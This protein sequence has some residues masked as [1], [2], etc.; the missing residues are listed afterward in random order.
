MIQENRLAYNLAFIESF[1]SERRQEGSGGG[2]GQ[3]QRRERDGRARACTMENQKFE[4]MDREAHLRQR[5]A[6]RSCP[7]DSFTTPEKEMIKKREWRG[8]RKKGII[9]GVEDRGIST[10]ANRIKLV[11]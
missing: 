3:R 10:A 4:P 1:E 5:D 7:A 2:T 8:E 11:N 6:A 9:N